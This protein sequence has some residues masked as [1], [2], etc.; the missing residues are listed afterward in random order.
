MSKGMYL[1]LGAAMGA[2]VGMALNYFLG[3]ADG[4][5]YDADYR[6]RLDFAFDEGRRAAEGKERELRR[7]IIDFRQSK[8]NSG[9]GA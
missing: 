4:T 5:T 9:T 3:P 8:P 2:A 1:L 7:Q 6:S